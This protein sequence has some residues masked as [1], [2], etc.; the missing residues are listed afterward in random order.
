MTSRRYA[1]AMMTNR[2]DTPDSPSSD[3]VPFWHIESPIRQRIKGRYLRRASIAIAL[4]NLFL[5]VNLVS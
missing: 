3:A 2:F 5:I 4:L 1:R